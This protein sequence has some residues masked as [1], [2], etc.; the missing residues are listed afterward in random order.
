LTGQVKTGKEHKAQLEKNGFKPV[1]PEKNGL[2]W[3]NLE[4]Q[5]KPVRPEKTG[6]NR[7]YLKEDFSTVASNQ[8]WKVDVQSREY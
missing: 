1:H 8:L 3:L 6:L 5:L 2:N 4:K 7:F